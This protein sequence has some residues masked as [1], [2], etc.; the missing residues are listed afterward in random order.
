MPRFLVHKHPCRDCGEPVQV[1]HTR[2]IPGAT[3][4]RCSQRRQFLNCAG[5]S[6]EAAS[7]EFLK[8]N[9]KA[10][11]VPLLIGCLQAAQSSAKAAEYWLRALDY[12]KP[13]EIRRLVKAAR[14]RTK[15]ASDLFGQLRPFLTDLLGEESE[16]APVRE[17]I[18]G[19]GEASSSGPGAALRLIPRELEPA[20]EKPPSDEAPPG[21]RR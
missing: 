1:R 9:G 4:A 2:D 5:W 15:W 16:R 12:A 20:P 21:W 13:G 7:R 8:V 18:R 17:V 10:A 19:G 3:C 11:L 6:D 14:G